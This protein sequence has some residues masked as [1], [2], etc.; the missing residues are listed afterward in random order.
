MPRS[1]AILAFDPN[2]PRAARTPSPQHPD[3]ADALLGKLRRLET[4]DAYHID[5][6]ST[7]VDRLL[8]RHDNGREER[9]S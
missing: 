3:S 5:F 2:R 8:S 9:E 6:I 7:L 4:V 1:A